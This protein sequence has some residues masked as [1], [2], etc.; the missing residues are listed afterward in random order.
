M[1]VYHLYNGRKN[2]G[3][4]IQRYCVL[5]MTRNNHKKCHLRPSRPDTRRG[6]RHIT[7]YGVLAGITLS[8]SGDDKMYHHI[9]RTLLLGFPVGVW[10]LVIVD[11]FLRA[12]VIGSDVPWLDCPASNALTGFPQDPEKN[13]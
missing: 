9:V 11:L 12:G 3:I 10:Q 7:I 1:T 8:V 6:K 2:N 13:P 4:V 5:E